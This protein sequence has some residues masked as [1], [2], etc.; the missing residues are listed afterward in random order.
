MRFYRIEERGY[1]RNIKKIKRKPIL[2]PVSYT[3]CLGTNEIEGR[4]IRLASTES[5][6]Y[7]GNIW[8]F[9]TR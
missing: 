5:A 4:L 7:L 2:L 1:L 6:V 9:R 8:N 3:S